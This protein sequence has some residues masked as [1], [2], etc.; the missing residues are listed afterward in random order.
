MNST[1][2]PLAQPPTQSPVSWQTIFWTLIPLAI[3]AMSQPG[4][5]VCGLPSRYRTYLRCS[6]LFC[7]ADVAAIV[8]RLG[9]IS[10]YHSLPF[11]TAV[12]VVIHER[13]TDC[14]TTVEINE[15]ES[16]ASESLEKMT[17]L[18]WLWFL[19]GTLPP[20]IKLM[21]MRGVGWV[22]AW[23]MMFLISWMGNE[24]LIL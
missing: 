5:R 9:V 19:L 2:P 10:G 18:R 6:P 17:W 24:L 23:G 7:L 11:S 14:A 1:R 12:A 3:S 13:Y 4:G 15:G 22:Q 8:T 20:A 21:S 16:H